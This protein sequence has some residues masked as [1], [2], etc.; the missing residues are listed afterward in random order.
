MSS[1]SNC[2][3]C[4]DETATTSRTCNRCKSNWMDL[5]TF[6]ERAFTCD[7][8]KSSAGA[9]CT[10]IRPTPPLCDECINQGYYFEKDKRGSWNS[11][12]IKQK[13]MK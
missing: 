12:T 2:T 8:H 1:R 3:H 11:S 7:E 4:T 6:I 13:L 5:A 10:F 9:M